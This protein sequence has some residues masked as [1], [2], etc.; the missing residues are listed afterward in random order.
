MAVHAEYNAQ[1]YQSG[2]DLWLEMKQSGYARVSLLTADGTR[3]QVLANG[4]VAAGS[5]RYTLGNFAGAVMALVETDRE[6]QTLRL[7]TL[8]GR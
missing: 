2:N 3:L 4:Y 8:H 5:H 6:K 7:K 1:L